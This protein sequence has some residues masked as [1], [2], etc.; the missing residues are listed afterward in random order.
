LGLSIATAALIALPNVTEYRAI[1]ACWFALGLG[2][3]AIVTAGNALVSDISE[4]QRASMLNL[5][6]LFFG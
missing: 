4:S 1:G 5:L 3:G 2:G 6:N